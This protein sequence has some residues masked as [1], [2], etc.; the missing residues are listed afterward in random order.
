[1]QITLFNVDDTVEKPWEVIAEAFAF[2]LAVGACRS[3]VGEP[4]AVGE[5]VFEL[6]SV[7]KLLFT[8]QNWHHFRIFN[9]PDTVEIVFDLFL[10]VKQLP[11]IIKMLP[12]AAAAEA[13]MPADR[14]HTLVRLFFYVDDFAVEAVGFFLKHLNINDVAWC[15]ERDKHYFFVR[16]GNAHA[17]RAGVDN[18]DVLDILGLFE[19]FHGAKII[20]TLAD[21]AD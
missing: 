5:A 4:F 7:V 17:F 15:S 11:L 21:N 12:F 16:L 3:A 8:A 10:F 1:M 20:K 2:F 13:K 19:L 18:F 6:V 14:F 9:L